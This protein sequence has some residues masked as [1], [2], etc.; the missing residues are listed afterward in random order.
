MERCTAAIKAVQVAPLFD[1]WCLRPSPGARCQA[2]VGD[3]K[4]EI[5]KVSGRPPGR[6]KGGRNPQTHSSKLLCK[7]TFAVGFARLLG[8]RDEAAGGG[9]VVSC[10]TAQ[11]NTV[12]R[13]LRPSHDSWRASFPGAQRCWFSESRKVAGTLQTCECSDYQC[14]KR[15]T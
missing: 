2:D 15:M 9:G 4:H 10:G 13:E 12:S 14:L 5:Y 7:F 3:G 8:R 6:G 1:L 11:A